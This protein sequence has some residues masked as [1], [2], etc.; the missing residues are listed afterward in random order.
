M[1]GN[2]QGGRAAWL[3]L[4]AGMAT[5]ASAQQAEERAAQEVLRQQE[6]ERVLREEQR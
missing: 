4:M 5:Q 2:R 6:R 3:L 1:I